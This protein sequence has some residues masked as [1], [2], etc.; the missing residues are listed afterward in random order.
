MV[1]SAHHTRRIIEQ[2]SRQAAYFV[3][4]P[5]HEDATQL[6]IELANVTAD[7]VVLDIACGAGAVA[8]HAARIAKQV[9]GIDLTPE[10]IERAKQHQRELGLTNLIWHV[11]DVAQLPFLSESFD[12]VFTRYSFHHLLH[13]LGVL[14][15]MVRVCKAGGQVAVADLVL[16]QEKAAAYDG[17]EV[18]RDPSHVHVLTEDELRDMLCVAGLERIQRVGYLFELGL[19]QLLAASFPRAGQEAQVRALLEMDVGVDR[20]G[21][22]LHRQGDETR[23]AYPIVI[24]A[25]TKSA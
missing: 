2:F 23:L 16:P 25:G 21:I 8:C 18:L 7:A 5:G 3:T 10:M 12:V 9:T 14:N 6:L 20:L 4:L 15:E 19:E 22:G 13:P 17:M 1:H 24:L 11:G